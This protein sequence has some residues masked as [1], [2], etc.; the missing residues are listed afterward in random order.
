MVTELLAVHKSPLDA[1]IR[2]P[3]GALNGIAEPSFLGMVWI[4]ESTPYTDD[5][6][7]Q[8]DDIAA[9]RLI[10]DRLSLSVPQ[11]VVT[12]GTVMHVQTSVVAGI[13]NVPGDLFR[14][15][16]TP[17]NASMEFNR[18]AFLGSLF[19]N[20]IP[21]S[22]Q[23]MEV[24][25]QINLVVDVSGSLGLNRVE[26]GYSEFVVWLESRRGLDVGFGVILREDAFIGRPTFTNERWVPS[27]GI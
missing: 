1:C 7:L 9:Y 22:N 23:R 25:D 3:L 21:G 12:L 13:G 15:V 11:P 2:S 24:L 10:L 18:D 17:E 26:P 20:V 27:F 6:Q 4:D 19:S 16:T 14:L 8:A 5:P